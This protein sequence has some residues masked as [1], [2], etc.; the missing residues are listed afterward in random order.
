MGIPR[1][2]AEREAEI[3]AVNQHVERYKDGDKEAMSW[4][5]EQF[6]GFLKSQTRRYCKKYPGVFSWEEGLHEAKSIFYDLCEEYTIGGVA[7]FTV[8]I[9]RKLPRRLWYRFSREITRR[10]KWRSQS[11][12]Q[13]AGLGSYD[14]VFI[15][16]ED[17]MR[18]IDCDDLPMTSR[19][20]AD[21]V[22]NKCIREQYLSQAFDALWDP[23]ILEDDAR[24]AFS[25]VVMNL[26]PI[27]D[28]ARDL[29]LRQVEVAKLIEQ[30]TKTLR[31]VVVDNGRRD[32]LNR[33]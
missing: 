30:S 15:N 28:V 5:I 21:D 23:D 3:E 10:R 16:P 29:G 6:M 7:Y 31:Q 22:E 18:A 24:E 32:S 9:Q 12:E 25:R 11:P 8:Y 19:S 2:K 20:L 33:G 4:L 1:T 27:K 14:G 13:L 26:E 17:R